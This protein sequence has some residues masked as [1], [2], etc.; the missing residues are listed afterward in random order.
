[1]CGEGFL[2]FFKRTISVNSIHISVKMYA[3]VSLIA[4]GMS[5][6][7]I[8]DQTQFFDVH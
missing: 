8:P 7:T 2:F 4:N 5:L 1:M 3:L 6:H